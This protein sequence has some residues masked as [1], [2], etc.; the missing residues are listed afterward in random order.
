MLLFNI[1]SFFLCNIFKSFPSV[2]KIVVC[3]HFEFGRVLH[4]HLGKAKSNTSVYCIV[5]CFQFGQVRKSC[6]IQGSESS[7]NFY[8]NKYLSAIL[9]NLSQTV[10]IRLFQSQSMQTTTSSLKKMAESSP[11]GFEN[12]GGKRRSCSL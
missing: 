3:I 8:L 2:N 11:N 12:T 9:L 5:N 6:I 7:D 10:N 1:F 4:C